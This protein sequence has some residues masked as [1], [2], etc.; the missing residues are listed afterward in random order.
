MFRSDLFVRMKIIGKRMNN[1]L[2]LKMIRKIIEV[3]I[4]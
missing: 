1:S 4:D 3:F 2:S